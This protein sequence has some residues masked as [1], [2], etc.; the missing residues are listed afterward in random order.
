MRTTRI[1]MTNFLSH[2]D[3]DLNLSDLHGGVLI[4]GPTGAGKSA[5]PRAI[6]AAMF[7][8]FPGAR[9]DEYISLGET[10]C[11]LVH[12]FSLRGSLYRVTWTRS[13]K[14]KSGKSDLQFAVRDGQG[15]TPLTG[16]GIEETRKIIRATLGIDYESLIAGNFALQDDA[17]R[18]CDPP[19]ISIDGRRYT[20]ASARIMILA[21]Q[22]GLGQYGEWGRLAGAKARE[23]EREASTLEAQ[24]AEVDRTLATRTGV[25]ETL[26]QAEALSATSREEAEVARRQIG[27]A[28]RALAV[29][30][31]QVP[32]LERQLDAFGKD[33]VSL[34]S[35]QKLLA[36][37]QGTADSYRELIA[38]KAE[39][40]EQAAR[41][42]ALEATLSEERQQLSAIAA[43][44][45]GIT[46]QIAAAERRVGDATHRFS[47]ATAALRDARMQA[48]RKAEI[49]EQGRKLILARADRENVGASILAIDGCISEELAKRDEITAANAHAERRRGEI[50]AKEQQIVAQKEGL[51]RLIQGHEKRVSV[52]ETVPC[53]HVAD[54]PARCPLL[55]D[56]RESAEHLALQ[57]EQLSSLCAW[58]SP[59]LPALL[60]TEVV[61]AELTRLRAE[62]RAEADRLVT[63]EQDIARLQPAE[64]ALAVI[65]T[66]SA[67]IPGLEAEEAEAR[68]GS[69]DA[70]GEIGRLKEARG[71]RADDYR[72]L[73]ATIKAHVADRSALEEAVAL[74][75]EAERAAQD[76]PALEEEIWAIGQ[77]IASLQIRLAGE[78]ALRVRL[79]EGKD[80]AAEHE[81]DIGS[82]RHRLA[83]AER[84][85]RDAVQR[86]AT[87]RAEL[88]RVDALTAEQATARVEAAELRT[89]HSTVVA[90]A[91]FYKQAPLLIL[92]N[93]AIPTLEE[94]ANRIL[95]RISLNGMRVRFETQRA[96]LTKDEL[97]DGLEIIV[98]DEAGERS[99]ACYSGGQRFQVHLAIR[100]ALAKLQ[101][102]RAGAHVETFVVDEGFGTQSPE[103]LAGIIEALRTIQ[104]E[105]PLMLVISHVE[106]LKDVFPARVEV[107]GGPRGSH[108]EL[109]TG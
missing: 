87:A 93:E 100:I 79:D 23:V 57:R 29:L 46:E 5:I 40:S 42:A 36:G 8:E 17:G 72:Q 81:L 99:L 32:D 66:A 98:T 70:K 56:A 59:P 61:N 37:K 54:L 62:R 77:E 28:E 43:E 55:K 38:R 49:E 74:L 53:L 21:Q 78:P 2:R 6:L 50:L 13:L 85:E 94:E 35:R 39:I 90:L 11:Q 88:A 67:S 41:A 92:E 10:E 65:E 48:S 83:S 107:S 27:E 47:R 91:E 45:R 71:R 63:L 9:A 52:M 51:A 31:V 105:F 109:V 4:C 95:G 86:A 26:R 19:P 82:A 1:S 30:Q 64:S 101:A 68:A 103:A 20:G 34:A 106:A 76:L 22:L 58:Q 89:R 7:G 3:T 96:L 25:E 102:R 15:C 33:R 84:T 104:D 12:E 69:E 24:V 60:P 75:P 16:K 80:E 44:G 18:F 73:D 108:A 14:T 97:A